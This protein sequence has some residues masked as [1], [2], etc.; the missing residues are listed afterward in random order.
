V[1]IEVIKIEGLG[2]LSLKHIFYS[3]I[4]RFHKFTDAWCVEDSKN[5]NSNIYI[6]VILCNVHVH[7]RMDACKLTRCKSLMFTDQI[8]SIN[9]KKKE[10]ATILN[11]F[12]I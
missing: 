12:D 8:Q 6:E 3:I 10:E 2:N 1:E 7:K 9:E 4:Y 5:L 11:F